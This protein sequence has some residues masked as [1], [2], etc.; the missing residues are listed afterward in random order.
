MGLGTKSM[1]NKF[2]ST[3]T[4]VA[5]MIF[6][7]AVVGLT[8]SYAATINVFPTQVIQTAVNANPSGTT[9]V[10]AAGLYRM[11]S[12]TPKDGDVFLGQPGAIL[13]GSRQLTSFARSG[14]YYIAGGQTQHGTAVGVCLSGYTACQYPEDLFFNNV[15]L[16]RVATLAEVTAGKRCD[17]SCVFRQCNE[18]H[19]QWIYHRKICQSRPGRTYL[20]TQ[21][22]D[23]IE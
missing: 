16:Q 19:D 10:I 14:S 21:L 5:F 17:H 20:R 23:R 18:C 2:I 13:N 22:D 4:A 12:V 3:V 7:S 6:S 9:F 15:P 1:Y 11:Q 8:R